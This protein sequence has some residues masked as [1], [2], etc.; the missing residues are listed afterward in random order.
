MINTE[1]KGVS[2]LSQ[3]TRTVRQLT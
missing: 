1:S 3:G 2:S